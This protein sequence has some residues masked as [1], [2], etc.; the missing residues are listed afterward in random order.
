[1][2]TSLDGAGPLH[3]QVY[4]A[5]R[6][7]IAARSFAPGTRL[8]S[9]RALAA[10]LGISRNVA[11][12]AYEQLLGEGWAVARRGSGTIVAPTLPEEFTLGGPG[13]AS[14]R[15]AGGRRAAARLSRA[16]TRALAIARETRVSWEIGR[17]APVVDFRFGRPAFGDFP[18]AVWCR[19]LGRRARGATRR[20]LD[21]GPPAG[22]LE[23]RTA[24]ADRLR[25]FRGIDATPDRIVVTNGSQQALDL[26]AR[27]L[28]DPGDRVLIEEP[29]YLGARWV[30]RA[31]GAALVP[32]PVDDDGM[33][34]PPPAQSRAAAPRLAY[35]TPSHQFPTGVVLPLARRVAL[36]AWAARA[37]AFVVE[38]DYDS[39]YRFAG[40][41]LQALAGLDA[42]GRVVYVGTFSKLMFPA[43]RLGYLVLPEPLVEPVAA[44]KALADTGGSALEQLALADFI[45]EGHFERHL[46]RSR[47][48]NAARREAL[49]DAVHRHFGDRAE[50]CG[51]ATGLHVLVW[52]RGRDG[53]P[54]RAVA[55][56]AAAAG[57]AVYSIA[58]YYLRPPRR[59]GILLGYGPLDERRIRDGVG[60]LASALV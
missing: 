55:R 60:R 17:D 35:V 9:T 22:R 36:L 8:P 59:S 7:E 41:R 34:V 44:A 39:E 14:A 12:L 56:R 54:V 18:H 1:M 16:G 3:Q 46:A 2:P 31:A 11:M 15:A 23:L 25:R 38:D 49:L 53:R 6:S 57:V 42:M 27:V 24:L 28:L 48:R 30:F 37:N 40:R 33:Q 45:R 51:A 58:P 20:D 10:D 5:L 19:L 4:R 13:A 29:H 21:Y 43:L 52:V 26:I 47:V 32:A 50:V